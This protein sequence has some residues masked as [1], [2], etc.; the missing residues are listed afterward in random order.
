MAKRYIL[1]YKDDR[2]RIRFLL[3]QIALSSFRDDFHTNEFVGRESW[4]RQEKKKG[5]LHT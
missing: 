2:D 5:N 3:H 1:L 4:K